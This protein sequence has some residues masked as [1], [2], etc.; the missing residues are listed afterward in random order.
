MNTYRKQ[1]KEISIADIAA[2]GGK[3][4]KAVCIHTEGRKELIFHN[5]LNE[6]GANKTYNQ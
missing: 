6:P 2:V 1:F 5:T 3:N 4:R